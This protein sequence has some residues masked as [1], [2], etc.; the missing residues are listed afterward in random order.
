MIFSPGALGVA[1]K[2]LS[3]LT[4]AAALPDDISCCKC[5]TFPFM[6][7]GKE[8]QSDSVGSTQMQGLCVSKASVGT[9][10]ALTLL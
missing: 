10:G 4:I 3:E 1:N 9:I 2:L 8:M 5:N 7:P 6:C